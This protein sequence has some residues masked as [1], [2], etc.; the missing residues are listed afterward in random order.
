MQG[1]G[2]MGI[3][4]QNNFNDSLQPLLIS[5]NFISCSGNLAGNISAIKIFGSQHIKMYNNNVGIYNGL[6]YQF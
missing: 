6:F 5:N 1:D 2:T 4:I 3:N